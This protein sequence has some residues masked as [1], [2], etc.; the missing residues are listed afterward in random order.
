MTWWNRAKRKVRT[1][2]N[3][4]KVW[5]Y[6]VLVALGLVVAVPLQAV[7]V[8]F[9]YTRSSVFMDGTPM[10]LSAIK[11]TRLYCD[12]VLVASEPGADQNFNPDMTPGTY[13]CYA[14]H[15]DNFNR[16]GERSNITE[17]VVLPTLLGAPILDE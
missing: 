12:D 17:K 10:P 8:E 14:V 5:A 4:F 3:R 7:T 2:W 9:T 16:E 11:E 13:S 6:G 15:V 1:T